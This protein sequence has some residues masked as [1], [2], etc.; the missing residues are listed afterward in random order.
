MA[1]L[2]QAGTPVITLEPDTEAR[3]VMGL[4]A[5][6][7]DRSPRVIEAAYD[8]TRQRIMSSSFLA[9][10]GGTTTPAMAATPAAG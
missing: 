1:R 4:R 3:R 5:M 2:Q 10:L 6:A 7:E 8:E 9:T